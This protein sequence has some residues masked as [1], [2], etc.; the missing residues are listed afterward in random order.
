MRVLLFGAFRNT[1]YFVAQCLLGKGHT[2]TLLLRKPEAIESDPF[3]SDYI[4]NG[5]AKL[6]RGDGL[7][8]EDVQKVW[9]VASSEGQVDL[10]FFGIGGEPTFS[11]TKGYV[12]NPLDLT[13]RSMSVLLSVLQSSTTPATQPKLVTSRLGKNLLR[14]LSPNAL[15]DKNDKIKDEANGNPQEKVHA[16]NQTSYA[17]RRS[18]AFD[19]MA[20]DHF[21][22]ELSPQSAI[23][24][25]Y[26]EEAQ[27]Y[28]EQLVKGR[29]QSLDTLLLFASPIFLA[30]IN[31]FPNEWVE[32]QATLYS[33]ILTAFLIESKRLM[34]QDPA[35]ASVALLLLIAQ[36]QQ[37]IEL[38]L[39]IPGNGIKPV[40]L[41]VY[42]PSPPVRWVNR[43]WFT[44]LGL[45]LSVALVAMLGK[46]WLNAY[47]AFRPRSPRE[48]APIRQSLHKGLEDW[49]ALHIIALLPTLLHVSLLL[50]AVGL[51]IAVWELDVFAASILAGVIGATLTFN[52]I[53]VIL[54]AIYDSCPFVTEVSKY[55]QWVAS[56]I[57]KLFGNKHSNKPPPSR[58]AE[59][60]QALLWLAN[61]SRD[62]VVVDCAYQ[63]MSGLYCSPYLRAQ[64]Q[65][66]SVAQI[67]PIDIAY[68][69]GTLE[70]GTTEPPVGRY[71]HSMVALAS[72]VCASSPHACTMSWFDILKKVDEFWDSPPSRFKFSANALAS[73]LVA[74]MDLIQRTMKDLINRSASKYTRPELQE[75]I[76]RWLDRALSLTSIHTQ[77]RV[78]IDF[79]LLEAIKKAT[80]DAFV[81]YPDHVPCPKETSRINAS[82]LALTSSGWTPDLGTHI[83]TDNHL[84]S[85]H[86]LIETLSQRPNVREEVLV[87]T[88]TDNLKIY[89]KL[90]PVKLRRALEIK[91]NHDLLTP[92]KFQYLA[93]KPP[94]SL[95]EISSITV[96]YMMLTTRYLHTM[97]PR[98]PQYL[99]IYHAGLELICV[100]AHSPN[101]DAPIN[102]LTPTEALGKHLGDFIYILE[103]TGTNQSLPRSINSTTAHYL[104]IIASTKIGPD[105]K[106]MCYYVPPSCLPVLLGILSISGV[107]PGIVGEVLQT[108]L[109]RM[110]TEVATEPLPPGLASRSYRG[111]EYIQQ[112]TQT[113]QGFS[114][115]L[116]I[117]SQPHYREAVLTTITDILKL[118]V[119]RSTIDQAEGARLGK[120]AV[121]GF[122]GTVSW[123][124]KPRSLGVN[125]HAFMVAASTLI[126]EIAQDERFKKRIHEYR[127]RT[128]LIQQLQARHDPTN[129][130]QKKLIEDL[131]MGQE[132]GN[133]AGEAA[134]VKKVRRT[135]LEG[136]PA[137]PTSE[138]T[139]GGKRKLELVSREA[140]AQP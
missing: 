9:N 26:L 11:L 82:P 44:S 59:D 62:P 102:S 25:I 84:I 66:N 109:N 117:G 116:Q 45:S 54:G 74:E 39:P 41:P 140:T 89:S 53:T 42:E 19:Q 20:T 73:V 118:L 100:F 63:A 72:Y 120:N 138:P 136:D 56:A 91:E 50:F 80:N 112:F 85:L 37:R 125:D 43:V 38:G 90:A 103:S 88:L 67:T 124:L 23:W 130:D 13:A 128:I 126:V 99:P 48:L 10:V 4:K 16:G 119:N 18:K 115:L 134:S 122:L 133:V 57:S 7:V 47:L 8:Q 93:P 32:F 127:E 64:P 86:A 30:S 105:F 28:D 95:L 61:N 113:D 139:I 27:E 104:T 110:R 96:Q 36:S 17:F 29:Q 22:E 55:T 58:P 52:I 97:L 83:S 94:T 137:M 1:G 68:E 6:V 107:K 79:Y 51:V 15:L 31:M 24:N 111:I 135:T 60:L 101:L 76:S 49:W 5:K 108:V 75:F 129:K 2:C 69:A 106:S 78:C 35:D 14:F 77:G 70:T 34:Q 3:M 81:Y 123:A 33:A 92:F 46:E 65:D 98:V 114:K 132:S 40:E 87:Q 12:I 131:K 71:I 21:G 121:N